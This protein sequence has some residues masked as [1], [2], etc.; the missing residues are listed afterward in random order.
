MTSVLSLLEGFA[1]RFGA[2][3]NARKT[4]KVWRIRRDSRRALALLTPD[5]L[6]DIGVTPEIAA[7]ECRKPFWVD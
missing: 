2:P 1:V 5:Q 6:N 7:R 3:V 4:L